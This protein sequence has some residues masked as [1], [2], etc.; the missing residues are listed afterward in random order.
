MCAFILI[1]LLVHQGL[2]TVNWNAVQNT[3]RG[4][5]K[6]GKISLARSPTCASLDAA[7]HLAL[8]RGH[9]ECRVLG[10]EACG[11]QGETRGGHRL[12]RKILRTWDVVKAEAV[13]EHDIRIDQLAISRSPGR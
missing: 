6:R 1:Q 7:T 13:P 12:H 10:E 4:V 11:V 3:A 2:V 5:P 8:R 9:I